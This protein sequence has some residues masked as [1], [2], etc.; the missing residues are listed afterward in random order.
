MSPCA[1]V[2]SGADGN[3][4]I[5]F[6]DLECGAAT[7]LLT[8]AGESLPADSGWPRDDGRDAKRIHDVITRA[9]GREKLDYLLTT[10]YHGD[11][12]GTVEALSKLLP[13][14]RYLD[15]AGARGHLAGAP[16]QNRRRTQY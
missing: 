14:G 11:H 15:H 1:A 12:F 3:L 6:I 4:E 10:H 9:A 16:F 8:P 5:Y 13:V 7:L 2:L